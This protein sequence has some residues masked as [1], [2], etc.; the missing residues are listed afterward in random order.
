MQ[1]SIQVPDNLPMQRIRELEESLKAEAQ[2][3][4]DLE[5]KTQL[6]KTENLKSL[7]LSMPNV[8]EDDDFSRRQD[9]GREPN[10]V[11]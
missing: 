10:L 4:H 6:S 1:M 5:H 2:F 9:F 7:L 3:F 11:F 8:G